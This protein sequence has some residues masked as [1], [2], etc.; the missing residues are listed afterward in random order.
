[1]WYASGLWCGVF[2]VCVRVV[3]ACVLWNVECFVC[4]KC[5]KCVVCVFCV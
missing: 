1:M 3:Y 2:I 4:V 5:E